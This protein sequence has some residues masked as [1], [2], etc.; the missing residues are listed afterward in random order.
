MGQPRQAAIF[1]AIARELNNELT[2]MLGCCDEVIAYTESEDPLRVEVDQRAAA[3]RV[4]Q[5]SER[6][7][8][9][10]KNDGAKAASI[11]L[12]QILHGTELSPDPKRGEP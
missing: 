3:A 7:L 8:I 2:I 11:S 5:I 1:E 6:L 9:A 10:A 12:E 4:H